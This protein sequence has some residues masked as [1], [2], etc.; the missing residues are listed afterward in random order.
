[1]SSQAVPTTPDTWKL[2]SQ[3]NSLPKLPQREK[4]SNTGDDYLHRDIYVDTATAFQSKASFVNIYADVFGFQS[5]NTTIDIPQAGI[6]Q[7]VCRVVTATAPLILTLNP[8]SNDQAVFIIYASAFDQPISYVC[9]SNTPILLDL[10]T[11]SGNLGA[12]ISFENGAATL[13]YSN[14]YV[15]LSM[16]DEE[17]SKSL[18]TQ[19]RIASLLFWIQPAIAISLTSH[20]ARATAESSAGA[21]LN[22]QAHALGQQISASTLTGPNL[23]YAPGK[24]PQPP[25]LALNQLTF[26]KKFWHSSNTRPFSMGL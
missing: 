26:P 13:S 1:M 7:I 10:S 15:D 22:L 21:L 6:I 2:Y 20:V 9:G 16:S 17:F 19:L 11:V 8:T 18:V 25:L 5:P 14:K 23:N 4:L 12:Q 24:P 3:S